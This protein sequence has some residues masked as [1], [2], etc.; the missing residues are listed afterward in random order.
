MPT[1]I[2]YFIKYFNDKFFENVVLRTN[3]YVVQKNSIYFE[4]T[5]AT[6]IKS[7]IAIQM[8]T[9]RLKFPK[10]SKRYNDKKQIF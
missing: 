9:G 3:L 1:P 4:S 5:N 10:K 6:E 2:D 7:L 8:M